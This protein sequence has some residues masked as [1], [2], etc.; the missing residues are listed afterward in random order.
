MSKFGISCY[1]FGNYPLICNKALNSAPIYTDNV[2]NKAVLK[3]NII[4]RTF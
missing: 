4:L 1:L 3:L 2:V